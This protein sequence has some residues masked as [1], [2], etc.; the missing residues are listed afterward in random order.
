MTFLNGFPFGMVGMITLHLVQ[1]ETTAD[2][3]LLE[4]IEIMG[5]LVLVFGTMT[6]SD[7]DHPHLL[8]KGKGSHLLQIPEVG[9]LLSPRSPIV[10]MVL[11]HSLY[12]NATKDDLMIGILR[13]PSLDLALPPGY[14]KTMTE[15]PLGN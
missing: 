14:E 12:M 7:E 1:Y 11:L 2:L 3:R 10:A 8:S 9:I 15:F 6:T 13:T 5:L 4:T